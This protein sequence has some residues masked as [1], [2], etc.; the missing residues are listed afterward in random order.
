MLIDIQ[1]AN[2]FCFDECRLLKCEIYVTS[3][4]LP[5]NI[6]KRMYSDLWIVNWPNKS[7]QMLLLQISVNMGGCK[8]KC[9]HKCKCSNWWMPTI[10]IG[11][12]LAAQQLL[13]SIKDD[14]GKSAVCILKANPW[15]LNIAPQ[16]PHLLGTILLASTLHV[17]PLFISSSFSLFVALRHLHLLP[18]YSSTTEMDDWTLL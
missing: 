7:K 12:L 1:P 13:L 2:I 15:H 14:V 3:R 11:H 16:P 4:N 9:K 17:F 5:V 8:I 18:H 10:R 6:S